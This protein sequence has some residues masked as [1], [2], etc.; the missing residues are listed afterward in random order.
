[1]EY[2]ILTPTEYELSKKLWLECF[3][4]D[5]EAFVDWYYAERSCPEYVLGA[6]SDGE[7]VSMLHMIPMRMP[8]LNGAE[9]VCLV[10]GVCTKPAFR[11]RGLCSRLFSLAFPIMRGRGF[12]AS[13]LQPFDPA[14]YERFGYRTHIV[15][16]RVE[17]E[18]AALP[19]ASAANDAPDPAPDPRALAAL[20]SR[21]MEG[22]LGYSVRDEGYFSAFI[23]EYSL[24]GAELKISDSGCCAGY[25]E[26]CVFTATELFFIGG[27]DIS[28]L[29]PGYEKYV[30]PL[31]MGSEPPRGAKAAPEPFSMIKPLKRGFKT[32]GPLYGFDRY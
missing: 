16:N 9:D 15:R 10:S 17:L 6:F 7:P 1:M 8:F 14:F 30:F 3:P 12:S 26:G 21:A 11:R 25:A 22:F 2:R 28:L 31:P 19:D 18:A 23:G 29:P 32:G 27:F 13:V 4:E 20:Y 5:G 24:P